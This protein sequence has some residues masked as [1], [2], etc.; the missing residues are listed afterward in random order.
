MLSQKS[1]YDKLPQIGDFK[2]LLLTKQVVYRYA[3]ENIAW[4]EREAANVVDAWMNS[5]SHRDNILSP[6]YTHMGVGLA[7]SVEGIYYWALIFTG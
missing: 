2:D 4:G 6:N 5:Q 1:D 3:G 7:Q